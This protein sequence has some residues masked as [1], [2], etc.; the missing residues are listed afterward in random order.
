MTDTLADEW[1]D[2]FRTVICKNPVVTPD[3]AEPLRMVFYAGATGA[4]VVLRSGGWTWDAL[5]AEIEEHAE[6]LRGPLQ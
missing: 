3:M 6:R 2:Y 5:R 4:M 1:D